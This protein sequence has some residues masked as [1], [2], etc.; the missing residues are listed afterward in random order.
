LDTE[1]RIQTVCLL[2]LTAVVVAAALFWLR[3]V[4]VPF[5]LSV[6]IA[7]GLAPLIDWPV[8]RLRVP[9]GLALAGTL[10][11][12]VLLL[13]M[14]ASLVTS[15]VG[16]LTER[17]DE[18][19]AQLTR[20]LERA[21][22][23]LP[24]ESL[25]LDPEEDFDPLARIPA[26]AVRGMLLSTTNAMVD[27]LSQSLLVFV[28]V[29]FLMLGGSR[30]PAGGVWGEI[31]RQVQSYLATKALLSMATGVLVW[32]VLALLGVD[33]AMV[34]GLF[35]FLL[36]FIPSV[37]SVIATLLPLPVVLLRPDMAPL[38]AVL[39]IALP[40]AIQFTIGSV[41]EPKIMGDALDLHPVT[42]LMALMFWGMLWG[43]PGML[44][45]TPITAIMKILFMRLDLTQPLAHLLAGRLG[46][47]RSDTG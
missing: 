42:I 6:F 38:T 39:A 43:I 45:A 21:V 14:L 7:L 18:Y 34:F 32:A 19:Y 22:E 33:L 27:I 8:R 36:N 29:V 35:A 40:G 17:G 20:L 30:T 41:L 9:H 24:A 4:M 26:G 28:F 12:A 1:R 5:V 3:P 46:T 2:F 10:V 31:A 47:F 25:G 11:V 23:L 44:L 37:G 15:S 13:T 16:Q